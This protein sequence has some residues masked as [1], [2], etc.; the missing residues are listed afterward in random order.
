V[1]AVFAAVALLAGLRAAAADEPAVVR[2]TEHLLDDGY[3][4]AYGIAACDLDGDGDLDL[5]SQDIRGKDPSESTLLWRENDGQGNFQRRVIYDGDPGWYERHAVADVDR[6]G[7]LDI[8][9]V[10]NKLGRVTWF[11]QSDEGPAAPWTRRVVTTECPRAYDVVLADLDGDGDLDAATSSYVNSTFRWYENPGPDG[12]DGEWPMRTIDEEMPETRTIRVADFNADGRPDLLGT[13]VGVDNTASADQQRSQVVWYECP[14]RPAEEP[15]TRHAIDAA[16][17]AAIHGEPADVDGDGDL[18]VVMAFGMRPK[19]AP[20]ERHEVA[21]YEQV[22]RT[23]SDILWERHTIGPLA[24]AFEAVAADL[25]GDGDP[26]VAA[27]AWSLG[28]RVVWF[29]NRMSESAA[30]AGAGEPRSAWPMHVLKEN[31]FAANQVIAADLD[32]DGR[33]DL[34][35]TADDGSGRVEGAN[36]LRWWR[37]EGR[38]TE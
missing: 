3:S 15:W 19:L 25:D 28:D 22:G 23:G 38:A 34:A 8:V 30:P 16:P 27:T 11:A 36:E 4:Y 9:V 26:D 20:P 21:W 2:F 10:D 24:S 29:E 35:A 32:G 31:F 6:N 18:D 5:T 1:A 13:A 33:V 7:R 37:N 12:R 14:E 17:W